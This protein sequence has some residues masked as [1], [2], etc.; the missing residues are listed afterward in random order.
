MSS[1][2]VK[3]ARLVV[4]MDSERR[5]LPNCDVLIRDGVIAEVSP[6]LSPRDVDEEVDATGCLVIPGL[7]NSHNHVFGTLFRTA[8]SLQRVLPRQ[9]ISGLFGLVEGRP[10]PPEAW[11]AV[12]RAHFAKALLTGCTLTADHHWFYP[13]GHPKEFVDQEVKAARELGIRLHASRGCITRRGVL[14]DGLIEDENEVLEH[15]AEM[16]NRYHDPGPHSMVRVFLAPTGLDCD[17][18]AIFTEMRALAERYERVQL[19]THVYPGYAPRADAV[20]RLYGCAPLEFLENVGWVGENVLLYHFTTKDLADV[21]RVAQQ[22][23]WVSVCPAMDMR[24]SFAGPSGALPPLRDLLDASGRVC[25]G[26]SNQAM[27]EGTNLLHDMHICWLAERLRT[28]DPKRWLT[29]RDVLWM[30]TRG[31]CLALGREE[32]GAIEAGM[33]ADLAL[34]DLEGIEMACHVDPIPALFGWTGF[35]RATIVNGRVVVR[36][37][38]LL[39][40]DQDAVAREANR[41]SRDVLTMSTS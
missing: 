15:A 32:L 12:A 1:L 23:S 27:N 4:T 19:H 13:A 33:G 22:E 17:T 14:P 6:G 38:R 9:W 11:D 37:G 29:A 5:E 36:E 41:W 8:P 20:Q 34:F 16:I 26:S 2:L 40:A 10:V 28:E 30:A 7:V 39:T 25:L 21:Q 24:M 18:R 31:G 3:H 35:T